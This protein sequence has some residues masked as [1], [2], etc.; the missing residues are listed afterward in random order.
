MSKF[1]Q[2]DGQLAQYSFPDLLQTKRGTL[3]G[4]IVS[5]RTVQTVPWFMV[6]ESGFDKD[7][8]DEACIEKAMGHNR[9]CAKYIATYSG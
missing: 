1:R 6:N 5:T 2:F 7:T 9:V 3:S 8:I 4:H